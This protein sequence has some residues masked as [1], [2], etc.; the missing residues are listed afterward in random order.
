MFSNNI[1]ALALGTNKHFDDFPVLSSSLIVPEN[2][3]RLLITL[4][5]KLPSGN[6]GL[7]RL[8]RALVKGS[9]NEHMLNWSRPISQTIKKQL[10]Y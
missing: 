4:S 5:D 8:K 2:L 1:L 3:E 9:C 10:C 6:L 7:L